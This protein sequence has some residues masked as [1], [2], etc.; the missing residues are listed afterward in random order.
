M[1]QQMWVESRRAP[2]AT[3][4]VPGMRSTALTQTATPPVGAQLIPRRIASFRSNVV[5][6]PIVQYTSAHIGRWEA[7]TTP[8]IKERA[9][10]A[11]EVPIVQKA[12]SCSVC[13]VPFVSP[14]GHPQVPCGAPLGCNA[15]R[16][17]KAARL[18]RRSPRR[19]GK[20]GDA[21]T[22]PGT[23]WW[24]SGHDGDGPALACCFEQL[25]RSKKFPL[26]CSF[27]CF[28]KIGFEG[29]LLRTW[30][31]WQYVCSR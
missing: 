26:P 9:P 1:P 3:A 27:D 24:R 6:G 15:G 21:C 11:T 29:Y 7:F 4:A 12:V 13:P 8:C 20:V 30:D 22:A 23:V 16:L 17:Q 25:P 19:L 28:Q 31:D 5:K 18:C 2:F 10:I 14:G